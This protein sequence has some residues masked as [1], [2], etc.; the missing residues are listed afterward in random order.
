[1]RNVGLNDV[2]ITILQ[3]LFEMPPGKHSFTCGDWNR[4]M[5]RYFSKGL[6]VFREH[7]F[8]DEHG[9]ELFQLSRQYFCHGLVNSSMKVD[10]YLEPV[11]YR[12]SYTGHTFQH[13]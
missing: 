2:N 6:I 9:P 7:R 3:K 4:S 12:F 1:M 5:S 10:S 11:A 8:F 13:I